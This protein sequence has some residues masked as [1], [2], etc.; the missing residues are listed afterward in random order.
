M[1]TYPICLIG[2]EDRNA[3]VIGGGE[4]ATRKVGSLL[5]AGAR[6][7]VISPEIGQ[8]LR[9][10]AQKG[11]ISLVERPYQAG[12]LQGELFKS[13]PAV[14]IAATDAPE[15]NRAV[16]LEASQLGCLVNVVDDPEH[17]NFIQP[18][19]VG[20][21]ELK[22]SISTGGASPALARRLRE[23]LTAEIG[24]EYGVL[25]ELL[26]ELRPALRSRF[27]AGEPRLQAAL[28][29][30]DSEVLEIIRT[31][32]IQAAR[33]YLAQFLARQETE[34]EEQQA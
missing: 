1:K 14:V 23:K 13:A 24:P 33:R 5:E 9:D 31:Q 34:Q 15:V 6:V 4:V 17:S 32:G 20:Y 18:A 2:L 29:M 27:G 7:T 28:Q 16:W 11:E 3:V 8:E 12:D 22:I 10:L 21:G 25:A 30:V 19:V 26:A